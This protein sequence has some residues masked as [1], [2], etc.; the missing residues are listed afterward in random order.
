MVQ[1]SEDGISD[2]DIDRQEES[3]KDSIKDETIE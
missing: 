1:K 2:A 3:D